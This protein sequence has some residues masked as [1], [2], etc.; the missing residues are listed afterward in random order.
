MAED[1]WFAGDPP[2][3]AGERR[4]LDALRER[5]AR[6]DVAGLDTS[7]TR[8]R[9]VLRP[10]H[11]TVDLTGL[12]PDVNLQIGWWPDDGNG[13]QLDGEWGDSALLDGGRVD[14]GMLT[15]TGLHAT[16]DQFASWTADWLQTQLIRPVER[17]EWLR[18]GDRVVASRWRLVDTGVVLWS[19]GF[20]SLRR[21]PPD[22]V[23]R[24]R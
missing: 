22:R 24:V 6:W 7:H 23:T 13:H 20:P 8:T 1:V 2:R 15:V 19:A 9:T 3:D 21:R 14:S 12:P 16:P 17:D 11:L 5:A 18:A 10:L 4:F